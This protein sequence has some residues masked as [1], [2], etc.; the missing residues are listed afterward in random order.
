MRVHHETWKANFPDMFCKRYIRPWPTGDQ[1]HVMF[2]KCPANLETSKK[3]TDAE[4]MLA[5]KDY[6]HGFSIYS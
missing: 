1:N 3:M 2:I 4:H 5:V 6:F